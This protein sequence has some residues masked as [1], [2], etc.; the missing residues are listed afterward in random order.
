MKPFTR[1]DNPEYID[2]DFIETELKLGKEVILQFVDR[3][4][5][6]KILADINELCLAHDENLCIRFYGHYS[7]PFDCNVLQKIPHVKCL[8]IDCMISANNLHQ[9]KKLLN[10]R[11]LCLGIFEIEDP[12]ILSA[13]NL[14]D[15]TELIIDTTKTKAFNLGHL[16]GFRKLKSLR[17]SG[18]TK[19]I[20]AIGVLSELET[21]TLYAIKKVPLHFINQLKQLKKLE[22]LL[23]GRDN[24]NELELNAIEHLDITWVRGLR[25]LSCLANFPQLKSLK[26]ED[27]I[28]LATLDFN[29]IYPHLTEVKLYNC[30]KL[31][32][33]EGL[34]NLPQLNT[35]VINQTNIDFGKF[36]E[37]ELP[38]SLKTFG[39]HTYKSKVDKEIQAVVE[40]KGF[41]YR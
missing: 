11:S 23:G 27:E 40:S 33:I 4:Y 30:K 13:S 28:Q 7:E 29:T 34:K 8:Y 39:F 21:L 5:T 31:E 22:I 41:I 19:N 6:D 36:M 9:V 15:L 32:T 18:H 3:S 1:I 35:L 20:D 14:K 25:D 37:Q 12:E 2:K 24:L 26:I 17:I 16:R 38:K 10:L